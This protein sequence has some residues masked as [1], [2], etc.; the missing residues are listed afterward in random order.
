MCKVQLKAINQFYNKHVATLKSQLTK[1]VHTS[2]RLQA[3]TERRN[4]RIKTE[5][6]RCSRAVIDHLVEHG[7]GVFVIGKN[8]GWKQ[9]IALGK[10]NN[11]N[12]VGL[13]PAQVIVMLSY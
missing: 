4:R 13:P 11:Q 12:F 9:D 10:L 2:R 3:V 5:L 8:D 6:H 1:A 7:I